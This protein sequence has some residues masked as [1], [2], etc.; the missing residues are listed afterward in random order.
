MANRRRRTKYEFK[1]DVQGKNWVQRLHLTH[2]QKMDLLKWTLYGVVCLVLLVIQD[3][4]MSRVHIFSATTDLVAMAILI[5]GVMEDTEN[6]SIFALAASM[7]YEFSGSAPGPYIIA[8]LTILVIA[9]AAFRQMYWRRGFSSNVLCAGFALMVYELAI[10]ATG[11]FMGLTY[12]SRIGVFLLTGLY[13]WIVMLPLY[14]L[15]R[16]IQKIGGETWK[17]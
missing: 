13:S 8:Y 12:W 6:G 7:L 17:E 16:A 10:Y 15:L 3:V 14:P 1:P 9:A 5:I 2:L 4:V 11:I